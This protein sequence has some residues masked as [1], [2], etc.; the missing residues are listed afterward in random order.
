MKS[1]LTIGVIGLLSCIIWLGARWYQGYLFEQACE[2]H[3]KRA[4]DANTVDLA[5][6]EL[7][8]ALDYLDANDMTTGSSHILFKKPKHDIG[9]WYDNIKASYDELCGIDSTHSQLEK[10]NVLIKLRE[11]LIDHTGEGGDTVTVPPRISVYP[12]QWAWW[13]WIWISVIVVCIGFGTLF[14]E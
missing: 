5:K 4:A 8:Y 13:S 6:Q 10:S 3:L 7:K 12:N 2:G 9:F 1:R 11:T 14:L